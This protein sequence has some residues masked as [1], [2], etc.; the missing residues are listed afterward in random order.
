MDGVGTRLYLARHGEVVNHGIYNGHTDVDM[1]ARGLAQMER[2]RNLLMDR[3]LSA[4]YSSDLTRTKKGAARVAEPHGILPEEIP[5]FRELHFGRWQG[6]SLTEVQDQY[7]DDF[8]QWMKNLSTFRIPGGE[9]FAD[10]RG[11]SLPKLQELIAKH[12]G[13][14]FAVVCH[15]VLN[16]IILAEALQLSY[17]NLLR[18]EQDYGC[19]NIIEYFPDWAVVKLMNG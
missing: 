14:E 1:T 2:L 13:R 11:R 10:L 5:Q 7:P 12:R 18:I 17:D 16:R 9:S 3:K 6:L 4:V 8:P 15:G 19:L